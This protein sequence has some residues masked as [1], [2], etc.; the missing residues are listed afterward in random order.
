MRKLVAVLSVLFVAATLCG[1]GADD[2][3]EATVRD[4]LLAT[5]DQWPFDAEEARRRQRETARALGVEVEREV[6]LAPG[7]EMTLVLIP[8]G[9]FMMGSPEDEELRR[10]EEHQHRVRITKPFWMGKYEVT[11]E[12]WETVMGANPSRFNGDRN[13]VESVCWIHVQDFLAKANARLRSAPLALPTEAQWEY[14]CRAGTATP[15]HFGDTLSTDQANYDGEYPY[16]DGRKGVYRER[17]MPVG[18]FPPNAWGLH[19]MHGNVCEWCADWYE[20]HYYERSPTEDPPGPSDG[21]GR[22]LRGGSWY[23]DPWL[24]RSSDRASNV[25]A[26]AADGYGFRV[27]A[28]C[29]SA[30][31]SR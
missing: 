16:G 14:A 22:L 25:S 18:S 26:Y 20:E 9:E 6:E 30:R 1:C 24:C 21:L 19:N 12:Q 13:P 7:V 15:F 2:E 8:P 28:S 4:R 31:T 27:V 17:T 3:G 10:D 29:G 11:Q 5:F 23:S